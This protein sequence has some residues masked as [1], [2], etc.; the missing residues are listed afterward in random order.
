LRQNQWPE[1]IRIGGRFRSDSV[2]GLNQKTHTE[3]SAVRLM[4][5]FSAFSIRFLGGAGFGDEAGSAR[6]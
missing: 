3:P 2:A 4:A 5:G 6:S 1:W